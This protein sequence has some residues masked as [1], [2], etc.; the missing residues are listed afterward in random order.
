MP[1]WLKTI[2]VKWVLDTFTKEKIEGWV[3]VLRSSVIP[4]VRVQKDTFI[5]YLRAKSAATDNVLDDQVVEIVDWLLE[6]FLP[7]STIN[8]LDNHP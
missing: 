8:L 1:T 7:D 5:A 3:V 4:W 6:A 2:L